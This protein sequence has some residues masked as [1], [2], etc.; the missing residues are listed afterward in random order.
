MA[1]AVRVRDIIGKNAYFVDQSGAFPLKFTDTPQSALD[2][3]VARNAAMRADVLGEHTERDAETWGLLT[4]LAVHD[5][6][7]MR[8]L[9]GMPRRVVSASRSGDC[10][11]IWVTFE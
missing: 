9:I 2:E 8:E 1:D 7:A 6:S 11:W 3:R 5:V 4:S 10:Q